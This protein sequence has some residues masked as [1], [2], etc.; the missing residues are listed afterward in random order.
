MAGSA[1]L[2]SPASIAKWFTTT[3]FDRLGA[4][5]TENE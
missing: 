4:S 2:A 1:G 5:S 3:S